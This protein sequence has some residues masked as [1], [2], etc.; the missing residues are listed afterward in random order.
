LT[1]RTALVVD[2][3]PVFSSLAE[4]LLLDAGVECVE[5]VGD[6]AQALDRLDAPGNLPDLL[7]CDLN[8]PLHDGVTVIRGLCERG[9]QVP[10][11]IVSGEAQAVINGVEAL[12]RMHGLNILGSIRKPMS[13]DALQDR[14]KLL[15][16]AVRT[17]KIAQPAATRS[18][19]DNA[20]DGGGLHPF[21]QAKVS[22]RTGRISGAEALAR[23][24]MPGTPRAAPS[25]FVELAERTHR[26]DALTFAMA[27]VVSRYVASWISDGIVLPCSIN[28]SPTTLDRIDF[29]DALARVIERAG[30]ACSQFTLEITETKP[31]EYGPRVLDVMTRL[32]LKG[33]GLSVD[34]FGTGYS[35][36]DRLQMLPFSE[37]K[38]D[39]SF[40]RKALQGGFARTCVETSVRLA[41]DLGLKVVAEGV[42]SDE[43]WSF[44]E[45]LGVDEVQGFLLAHPLP[46]TEFR[47]L[48]ISA[49][50][51]RP[52][53]NDLAHA[54]VA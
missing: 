8:M 47:N 25:S 26:I 32:R 45:D 14:M 48:L 3:D 16:P 40:I 22:M 30:L 6:G 19:L 2:D 54:S 39:Q 49:P 21:F 41:N 12:A 13:A 11:I 36:I 29:P 44:L 34:D 20:I 37:L 7:L 31:V 17:A 10:I 43:M 28:I 23:I 38:I 9:S 42:E 1:Y 33:F 35:N 5:L 51:L 50:V 27:G 24:E 18:V 15:A 4:E 53:A 52:L 46:P